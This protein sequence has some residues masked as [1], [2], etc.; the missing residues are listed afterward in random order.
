MF[1]YT[2]DIDPPLIARKMEVA[3][4]VIPAS[5]SSIAKGL[6]L[7]GTYFYR[8][9]YIAKADQMLKNVMPTLT[10]A[11]Y[12]TNWLQFMMMRT[13]TFYEIAITGSDA[14]EVL[15]KFNRTFLPNSCVMGAN[16]KSNLPLLEGKFMDETMV[17][18]CKEGSCLLPVKSFEDAKKQI[19][20]E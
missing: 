16:K 14:Q 4:N 10:Q 6:F 13:K 15:G 5:N 17:F 12:N 3:D 7:L 9:D 11:S 2:S 8:P 1:W 19:T 20:Y 18:V